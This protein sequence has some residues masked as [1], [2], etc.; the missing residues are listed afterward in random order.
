MAS[1]VSS[2]TE[3]PTQGK[4]IPPAGPRW[5]R[6]FWKRHRVP[7]AAS[8][9][10]LPA[11]I[12]WAA[13]LAT[14]GGDLAA[15][16]SWTRFVADH[17]GSPYSLA[18][19][20]GVHVGNYSVLA[21]QLMALLGV[22]TVTVASG[23]AASWLVGCVFVRSGVRNPIWPTLLAVL[24]LWGNVASGRSTF[25]LG[26][27]LALAACLMLMG[28]SRRLVAAGVFSLL[29]TMAS[30][31]AGLFLLVCG[32]GW[33]LNRD[34]GKALV[35]C[36][37]PTAV[38]GLTTL[39]FPFGGVM[40]MSTSDLWKPILFSVVLAAFAPPEWR[41]LRYSAAT[42]TLGIVLSALIPTPVG[43]NVVRLAEVFGGPVLLAAVLAGKGRLLQRAAIAVALVFSIQW[44]T[45]H[46]MHVTK[47]STPVPTWA[48][49]ARGV[50]AALD[51]LGADQT[52]V[53]VV[54]AV[55]HRETT[56]LGPYVN[57]ARGWNRQVDVERGDLFYEGRFSAAKYRSWLNNWA[58]SYVVLPSGEP[59]FAAKDEANLVKSKPN[60]LKPVWHDTNW[61]IYAVKNARPMATGAGA[62]VVSSDNAKVTLR[63]RKRGTVNLRI[64]Y[65]PWLRTSAGCIERDGEWVRLKVPGAGRY[66]IDSSYLGPWQSHC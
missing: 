3:L 52:R 16:V 41:V 45:S 21:P 13:F 14:G 20:G 61:Q 62:S 23:I 42:Y 5:L 8:V 50:L 34:F 24:F 36:V 59:D 38:V 58:V 25:A 17:P 54:P 49:E 43:A 27:A 60:W 51:R 18:W 4:N 11:Y 30:P 31:V 32:A 28:N 33:L 64:A 40:P 47:M 48:T 1:S 7:I 65:S 37:P 10:A 53:E 2:T 63:A 9:L 19:Y 56:V 57:L 29:A 35:L 6:P 66:E 46:T 26:V 39:F 44:V 15:Q 22:R 55:N 12:L